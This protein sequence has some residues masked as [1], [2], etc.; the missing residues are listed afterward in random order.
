MK[1]N[2]K[3]CSGIPGALPGPCAAAPVRRAQG[4]Q[5]NAAEAAKETE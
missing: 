2:T 4:G 3:Q 1:T 5:T